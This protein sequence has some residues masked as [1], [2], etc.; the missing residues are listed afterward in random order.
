MMWVGL[1]NPGRTHSKNRHNIGF[2]AID[3]I[4]E[5]YEFKNWKNKFS[6]KIN[7]GII[8]NK[9]I[10]LVK[11]QNFMNNSGYS[12]NMAKN[13]FSTPSDDIF[14]FYDEIDLEIGKLRVKFGGGNN[15]HNGLKNI[16]E[17]ISNNYWK[18]KIGI[19]RPIRKSQVTKWVLADFTKKDEEDWLNKFLLI[20]ANQSHYLIKKDINNFMS[21]VSLEF[22]SKAEK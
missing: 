8:S 10:T 9:K 15:G 20:I 6:C 17:K 4:K 11:P 3:K 21:K 16:D 14:V 12:I 1:G 2:M 13:F 18:V 19:G 5:I 7:N 22:K